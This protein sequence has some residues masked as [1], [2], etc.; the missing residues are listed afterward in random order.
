ML[1]AAEN[2]KGVWLDKHSLTVKILTFEIM[3]LSQLNFLFIS[4]SIL[5]T[6]KS[7]SLQIYPS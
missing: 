3:K 5:R 1:S 7:E 4:R 2:F 6:E